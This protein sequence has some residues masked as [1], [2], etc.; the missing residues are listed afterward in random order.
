[1]FLACGTDGK[2][3]HEQKTVHVLAGTESSAILQYEKMFDI[4][5]LQCNP[6]EAVAAVP[7]WWQVRIEAHRPQ[8]VMLFGKL[9]PDG[10]VERGRYALTIPHYVGGRTDTPPI[11]RYKKGQIEGI[12]TLSDNSK[13]IVNAVSE[14]EVDRV[15][16]QAK[17]AID[18]KLIDGSFIKTG[19][20]KG[21][22]LAAITLVPLYGKYFSQGLKETKPDWTAYYR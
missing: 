11:G 7:E 12:L 18:P 4:E 3:T 10:K 15:L 17:Q 8:L 16:F 9:L 22:I 13:V 1:M 14:T 21:Q 6:V 20:R 5:A 19:T 2:P